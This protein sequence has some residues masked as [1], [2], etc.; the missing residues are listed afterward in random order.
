MYEIAGGSLRNVGAAEM[1]HSP[2]LLA[3]CRTV[4]AELL[5]AQL[6]GYTGVRMQ[7]GQTLDAWLGEGFLWA[8]RGDALRETRR[9]AGD[10]W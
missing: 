2:R 4:S 3:A 9:M 1:A 5:E 10:Q 7:A 8:Q 6:S